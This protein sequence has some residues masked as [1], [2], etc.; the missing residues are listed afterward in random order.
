MQGEAL[1]TIP[2]WRRAV[3]VKST[4]ETE[5]VLAV[6]EFLVPFCDQ[7]G[8]IGFFIEPLIIIGTAQRKLPFQPDHNVFSIVYDTHIFKNY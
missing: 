8:T 7:K 3:Q 6:E 1:K 5:R 4:Q 2:C